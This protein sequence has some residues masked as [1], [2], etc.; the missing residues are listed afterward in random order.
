MISIIIPTLRVEQ[1]PLAL[2]ITRLLKQNED[3]EI[4]FSDGEKEV[5]ATQYGNLISEL[6]MDKGIHCIIVD[7]PHGHPI[8]TRAESMNLGAK[9][10][11]GDILLFLHMD[12]FLPAD[13]L[14]R[15]AETMKNPDV[16]GG[17]FLKGYDQPFACHLT[18]K[19]LNYRTTHF[20]KMVGTNAI[21]LR[22]EV[23]DANPFPEQFMEDV[24]L[25]D[26]LI[27]RY[28]KRRIAIIPEYVEVSSI[29]YRKHGPL[30]RILINTLIMMLYRAGRVKPSSLENLYKSGRKDSIL[31]VCLKAC[32]LLWTKGE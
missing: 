1:K 20:K 26:Q 18:E 21:F 3:F 5:F 19:L 24:A 16:I 22:K 28:S 15:I 4:I 25:S 29:K 8:L 31:R 10:A 17:G 14:K 7:N 30:K 23:C 13:G 2:Q 27:Q 32:Q 12:I 11:Q 6:L 9:K